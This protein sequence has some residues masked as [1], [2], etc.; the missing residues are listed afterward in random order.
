MGDMIYTVKE[1][2][3]DGRLTLVTLGDEAVI[4]TRYKGQLI[5]FS[6]KCPHASAPLSL[7]SYRNGVVKCPEHSYAFDVRTGRTVWPPDEF[8]R[9]KKF[10]VQEKNDVIQVRLP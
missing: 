10:T 1:D 8:C 3:V 9:L 4:L 5:A 7:A 6:N 2:V